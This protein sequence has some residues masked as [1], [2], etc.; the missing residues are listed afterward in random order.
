M[1]MHG[2]VISYGGTFLVFSD[3]ARPAI[4]LAAMMGAHSIFVFTHDSI[5]LGEDGPTH[6]PIEH[7]MSLRAIPGLTVFR[8]ADANET[9]QCWK[10]AIARKGPAVFALT[11]QK[12]PVLDNGLHRIDEGV[13]RGAYVLKEAGKSSTGTPTGAGVRPA[14]V[15]LATGSE[16]NLALASAEILQERGIPARVVS[17]PSWEIFDEQPEE[18]RLKILP[19]A[20]PRLAIE[21]GITT[22]WEKYT[23]DPQAVVG[24]NRFGASAPG[25]VA[26]DRLGFNTENVVKMAT[27]LVRG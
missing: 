21:A 19:K 23:H 15:L 7:I 5:A 6:Q 17:M 9:A 2:G 18:Y 24:L 11:R 12:L 1:A 13:S 27:N 20:I 3:Y 8:P 25:P 14:V 26:Y 4:R 10:M 22:G 16:V